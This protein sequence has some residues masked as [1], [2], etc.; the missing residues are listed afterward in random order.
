MTCSPVAAMT[1]S[2]RASGEGMISL[3]RA[4]RRLVSPDMADGTTTTS[5]PHGFLRATR[6][7]TFLIMVGEPT[8]VPPY[9]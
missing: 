3:A 5:L 8:E 6:F 9:F 4:I 7:A 1:S 2:L